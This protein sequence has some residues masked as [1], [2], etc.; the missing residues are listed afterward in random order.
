MMRVDEPGHDNAAGCVDLRRTA[1]MQVR[2]DGEDL[3]ALDQHTPL[4]EVSDRGIERH[5]RPAANNIA[6][7]W[8]PA[9]VRRIPATRHGRTRREQVK[10]RRGDPGR[11]RTLQ[12]IAPRP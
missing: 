7:A 11:R 4:T 5:N 6:P 12:K 2:S 3:L 9:A 1:R 8:P 10:T